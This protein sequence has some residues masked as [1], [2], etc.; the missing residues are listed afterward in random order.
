[1]DEL[2]RSGQAETFDFAFIDAD[3]TNYENYYE[4]ALRLL[5]VGGLIAIDNTI[6]SGKV[7]DRASRMMTRW[8]SAG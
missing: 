5:R 1:L 6:W 8:R 7:A 4:R 2:V 3:K